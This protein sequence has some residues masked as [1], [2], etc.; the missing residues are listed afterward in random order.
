MRILF[1]FVFLSSV[2]FGQSKKKQIE[3][4]NKRVDSLNYVLEIERKLYKEQI[5]KA[6]QKIIEEKK[7]H[8]KSIRE[9]N[10]NNAQL[11]QKNSLLLNELE[12]I[13]NKS[14]NIDENLNYLIAFIENGGLKAVYSPK[15]I[16]KFN[17]ENGIKIDSFHFDKDGNI[18]PETNYSGII[19]S[20]SQYSLCENGHLESLI[21]YDENGN[22]IYE[23]FGLNIV[24][25]TRLYK[26]GKEQLLEYRYFRNGNIQIIDF[27][28]GK[29]K[30][31]KCYDRNNKVIDCE[32]ANPKSFKAPE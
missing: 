13:K 32:L 9:I 6:Q 22:L 14:E 3:F 2:A 18:T 16:R 31:V 4:L 28:N 10:S 17:V 15:E 1:A 11:K 19:K 25:I 20:T 7:N 30:A 24:A 5:D 23:H 26:E 29:V 27:E 21:D 8:L 12:E